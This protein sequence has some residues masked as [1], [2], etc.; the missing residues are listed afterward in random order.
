LN[1][2]R[3]ALRRGVRALILD[4]SRDL[5]NLEGRQHAPESAAPGSSAETPGPPAAPPAEGGAAEKRVPAPEPVRPSGPLGG[6]GSGGETRSEDT[7]RLS[8][9][10][11][12]A[13]TRAERSSPVPSVETP[14][15]SVVAE[16]HVEGPPGHDRQASVHAPHASPVVS[17]APM[18]PGPAHG[19]P[20]PPWR[21]PSEES[22]LGRV[23][24]VRRPGGVD[25][26]AR[27]PEPGMPA[28]RLKPS[29]PAR[30]GQAA[31]DGQPAKAAHPPKAGPPPKAAHT[32]RSLTPPSPVRKV[33]RSRRRAALP[34][35]PV[36]GVDPQQAFS[37][38]GVCF[39]YFINNKCWRI[40]DAYC[41]TALH[42]CLIRNCPVYHLHRDALERRFAQK[43]QHF[44]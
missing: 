16:A 18:A 27:P 10:I 21:D 24:P 37:R 31:R 36:D 12:A 29:R 43:F 35:I 14:P 44:W 28:Q 38:T 8:E 4:T 33:R 30:D 22:S 11:R 32:L 5:A 1:K 13:A 3:D 19:T 39:A 23:S 20:P 40:R 34:D 41:N 26:G 15:H 9:G 6:A 42:M 7:R 17:P 2:R 25:V